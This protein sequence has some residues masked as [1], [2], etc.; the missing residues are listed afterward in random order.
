MTTM[1][2]VAGTLALV[3][4]VVVAGIWFMPQ[5]KDSSSSSSSSSSKP[6]LKVDEAL[7]RQGEQLAQSNGCTSCHT[8]DGSGGVGP[9]WKGAYGA[10]VE[11]VD[12][13]K[14]KVDDKY[15]SKSILDPAAE[16]RKGS[17]PGM[18]SFKGKLSDA[19]IKAITEYV[20]SLGV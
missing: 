2:K 4:A 8:V 15:I 17:S 1:T 6:K 3:L 19:Q 9:S 13:N 12:G 20:K 7:A 10:E 18:Q 11:L 14:V 5:S 16:V